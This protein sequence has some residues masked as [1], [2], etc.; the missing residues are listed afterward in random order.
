MMN[1]Q[2]VKKEQITSLKEIESKPQA[3]LR[4][5]SHCFRNMYFMMM[6]FYEFVKHISK[7]MESYMYE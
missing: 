2:K 3:N 7:S 4:L 5:I 6:W 1:V